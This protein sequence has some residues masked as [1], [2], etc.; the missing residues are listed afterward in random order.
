[1][2]RSHAALLSSFWCSITASAICSPM[3]ST[4]LRDV[5][6]SWKIMAIRLPRIR[7]ISSS[8]SARRS[9]PSKRIFP[10][11]ILP[12]G[13]GMSRMMDRAC[14][15]F[16]LPDD[17]QGLPFV[18]VVGEPVHRLHDA[19]VGVEVGLQVPDG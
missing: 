12:G 16:P 2:A 15:L 4:G 7:R 14:T 3:V 17:P 8:E 9:R 18:E 19:L 6:G 13:V 5:I 1:M 10:S 11:T